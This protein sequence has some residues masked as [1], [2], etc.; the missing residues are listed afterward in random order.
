MPAW[1]PADLLP[2]LEVALLA[3]ALTW[4]LHRLYDR[5][6]AAVVLS[7]ALIV[8][9]ILGPVLAGGELFLPL[10]SLRG[11]TPFTHLPPTDPHGNPLQGDLIQLVAP[12]TAEVRRAAAEGRWPLWS[13]RMGGGIPLLADPQAQALQPLAWAALPWGPAR[14]AGVTAGLRIYCALL[15]TFL[16]LRR[17]GLGEASS[18]AGALAW[19]LGG[20]LLLW[21]GWPLANSGV[22]LPAVLYAVSRTA[23]RGG[24]RDLVL[25]AATL[26][27][28]LAAGHPETILYSGALAGVFLLVR[29][30]GGGEPCHETGG[31]PWRRLAGAAGAS[32]LA[33]A[34]AAP[35]LAPTAA[36]LPQTLRA[37]RLADPPPPP[38]VAAAG[39]R[40]A[41]RLIPI[42]AP[43]TF[44]NDRYAD[45]WGAANIN[46]DASGFA[47]SATLLLAVLGAAG[48]GRWHRFPG[49]RLMAG[50][51][52]L[53]L[54]VV[55]Q[56]PGVVEL[57]A[58]LPGGT[59][60]GY[61]HRLLL[62]LGFGLAYLAACELERR[63]RGMGARW[64]GP[65]VAL[66]LAA[67][68]VAAYAGFR[69]PQD[70]GR[71]EVLRFGWVHWHLRFLAAAGLLL[72][73]G[74]G[75]RWLPYGMAVLVAAELLLAHRGANP[76]APERLDFP[77]PPPLDL[78]EE[79]LGGAAG[80]RLAGLE[81]ALPP[82][83]AAVYGLADARIYS[84][85]APAA[86]AV[87]TEAVR[88]RWS[89]EVPEFGRPEHPLY[90]LLAV[91]YLVVAPEREPPSGL[92][93]LLRHPSGQVWE[94]P[95]ALPRLFLPR[96]AEP[97]DAGWPRRLAA[98]EDFSRFALA[99]DLP[100]G[101]DVWQA[102]RA[103]SG[104][105]ALSRQEPT[106]VSARFQ[107]P[108]G[109]LL[110]TSICQ[111]GGWRLLVDGRRRPTTRA[112][113]P[114]LAAWLPPGEH[115]IELLYRPG[116]FLLGCL[117]AALGLA[118]GATWLLPPPMAKEGP[119]PRLV[120]AR[121][122]P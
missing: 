4:V 66:G 117:A 113:G 68:V 7:F 118:V 92:R 56:P 104:E 85:M 96:T 116:A 33:L 122:R 59:V 109:R 58:R 121:I 97:Q 91:R 98:V 90:D 14:G 107:A 95:T 103:G 64:S 28:L 71:L 70:P 84:P 78:L 73:V 62:L 61:H 6:P 34:A 42:V 52:A 22:W 44:G 119:T 83:L 72:A 111:D 82:N 18:L 30:R 45:Y 100:A 48:L 11:S 15:F 79:R 86:Y 93:V 99:E 53:C 77:S 69:H 40:A 120:R 46:E 55:A 54:L 89:G 8:A 51:C 21:L 47:G 23:D 37:A 32:L 80:Y 115:R 24:R 3:A 1:S 49:E 87:A 110:T 102:R 39:E 67:V 112:N 36:Y 25:L 88:T 65:L 10:D 38:G 31:A 12:A 13:S 81:G 41:K 60:S 106:R 35:A 20:F 50:V 9:A 26:W 105:L 75:R 74:R 43:N 57:M 108:E 17:Q 63:S 2:G 5:V 29:L 101:G 16:L 94:R 27:A 76:P 19:G 114:F